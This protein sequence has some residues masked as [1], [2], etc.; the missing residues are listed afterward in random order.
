MTK[1]FVVAAMAVLAL[2][3]ARPSA[4]DTISFDYNGAAGGGVV[5]ATG[6]DWKPGN[7][8]LVENA[9]G[10][11]GTVYY[12]SNL[13]SILTTSG[14]I[15]DGTGGVYYTAVAAFDVTLGAGG[16]FNVVAGS[17]TFNIYVDAEGGNDLSGKGFANDAGSTVILTGHATSGTGGLTLSGD[18]ANLDGFDSELNGPEYGG[19]QAGG[20]NYTTV[21][22]LTS[23]VGSFDVRVK[24]DTTNS[25]YFLVNPNA[26]L[27]SIRST[28]N[29]A[30]PFD[31]VNPSATF[32]S[33]AVADGDI[34]GATAV[35]PINGLCI[36]INPCQIITQSDASTSFQA[37]PEPASLT[38]LGLGL[39]GSAAARRRQKKAQQQA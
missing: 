34:A 29:N 31:L 10:L 4:A 13:N 5:N 8:L 11:T 9:G 12:Q 24:V 36:G 1:R 3:W 19:F 22:T 27:V 16:T 17:G 21:D 32:S 38:L 7:S 15:P 23:T 20:D 6:F 25:A 26:I 2:A 14:A 28:G 18:V 30:L 33:N 35:G 39:A 37:V